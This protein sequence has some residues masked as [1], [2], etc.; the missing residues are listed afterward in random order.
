MSCFK[1]TDES[2]VELSQKY[3]SHIFVTHGI[4]KFEKIVETFIINFIEEPFFI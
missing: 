1:A 3:L 4:P 2:P